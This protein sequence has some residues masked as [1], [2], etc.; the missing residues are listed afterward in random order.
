MRRI[1]I[2]AVT[3]SSLEIVAVGHGAG[4]HISSITPEQLNAF[5]S[6]CLSRVGLKA[7]HY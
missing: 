3:H 4:S 1:Q 6:V 5:F 2:L 7:R